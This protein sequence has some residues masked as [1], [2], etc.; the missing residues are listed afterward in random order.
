MNALKRFEKALARVER[1]LIVA[2]LWLM[3]IFT[4]LQVGLRGL[5]THRHLQWANTLMGH[6]DW[7]EAF[8]RLLVLWLSF[9]GA[10]LLTAENKH[11]K[12][13]IFSTILPQKWLPVREVVLAMAG[14]LICAI[15]LKVSIGYLQM[16]MDTGSK[17]FLDLPAWT[18][19]T[20]L[21]AG[22]ALILF[23]FIIRALDQGLRI[24]K[25]SS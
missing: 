11:I 5:Y 1:W 2:L 4:F 25:R 18:G 10:S 23:R 13:D 15:M 6:L 19:Q 16:E 24:I 9:L 7:S 20:I 8:V 22:F 12:I 17:M 14:I 3:V 21:P